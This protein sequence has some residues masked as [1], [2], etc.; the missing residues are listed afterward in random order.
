M[1]TILSKEKHL[2]KEKFSCLV[3]YLRNNSG[4]KERILK[5]WT[6]TKG[7]EHVKMIRIEI[8]SNRHIK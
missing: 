4:S 5:K 6:I 3:R 7:K 1:K 2:E 8:Q